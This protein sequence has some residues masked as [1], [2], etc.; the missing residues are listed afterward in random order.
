VGVSRAARRLFGALLLVG[1]YAPLHRLL[2]PAR[3]GPA[4][5]AT[6]ATAEAAWG[7][8]VYGTLIALGIAAIL[9]LLV[10]AGRS[11]APLE[12]AG[13]LL[14][15][16]GSARFATSLGLVSGLLSLAAALALYHGLPSS[17]DEMAQLLHARALASGRLAIPLPG[18]A[19][20]WTIQNGMATTQG[21]ASIYP[22]LHTL[23]LALGLR[24]GAPWLVGPVSVGVATWAS[25]LAFERLLGPRLG[26]VTGV[27]LALSP[28]WVLLGGTYLSHTSAAAALA[29]VL[30]TGL[31][32]RD[33]GLGWAL[34]AGAA[35][36][37][38]VTSRPWVGLAC[39]VTLLA[40]LWWSERRRIG[41]RLLA[42]CAGG[43][44]FALLLLWWNQSLFGGALTLGYSAT[45]GPAHGL[46]FHVDPWGNFY[47]A[48]EGLA[49]TGAD[50]MQL[51]A[52]LFETPLPAV[53][54]VGAAL[55]IGL[56]AGGDR[57]FIAWAAAAVAANALYWHHG[58][59]LGPRMLYESV[60]AWVALSVV[61]AASLVTAEGVPSRLRHVV[62]WAVAASVVGAPLLSATVAGS[63]SRGT[64]GATLPD[65]APGGPALVFAHGSWSSRVVAR[66][67]AAGMR[68]DS[69]ETALRRN[70]LCA[71]DRYAR[72][73]GADAASGGVAP[74]AL[75]LEPLPGTPQGLVRVQLSPGNDAWADPTTPWDA[76]CMREAAADASGTLEL[77]ALA[78]RAPP[79]PG[80]DLVI[81]R[82]MGPEIDARVRAAM[83]DRQAF[84]YVAGDGTSPPEMLPY[85]EGLGRLW[86]EAPG[87]PSP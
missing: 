13:Q 7:V 53:A 44:P 5:E 87:T 4:G 3:V 23:L 62:G 38:A 56:R 17:V 48:R 65:P 12:R 69:V 14:T 40:V 49:Y 26:R 1:A 71:M 51:G 16:P 31:R 80:R 74:P 70:D 83:A 66:L 84:V 11:L 9:V 50:L 36:G 68:R 60:P 25:T 59:H 24:V 22:P 47:G 85:D 76:V 82:D 63:A 43:V 79:L 67:S 30:W 39:S 61:A 32:A 34:A 45:F 21:W 77:E 27:A 28:F 35:T 10:P 29:L 81:A 20:A 8:G 73:R 19:S 55:L 75:D 6:R 42:L 54:L 15:W 86:G 41:S 57:A 78:W 64:A 58:I 18:D 37:A 52:H 2:D 33:G 72:W 46:G